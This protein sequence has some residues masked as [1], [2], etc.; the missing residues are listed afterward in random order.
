MNLKINPQLMSIPTILATTDGTSITKE[1]KLNYLK[2]MDNI[3][4]K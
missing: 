3:L 1:F 4:L 2:K